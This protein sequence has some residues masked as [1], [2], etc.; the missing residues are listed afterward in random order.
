MRSDEVGVFNRETRLLIVRFH[1][2]TT[3][4]ETGMIKV[5]C[6]ACKLISFVP[7][8]HALI[9]LLLWT[10]AISDV[11]ANCSRPIQVPVAISGYIV[12]YRDHQFSGMIPDFLSLIEQKSNCR[13]T[14]IHVPKNRQEIM[15]ERGEADLLIATVKTD[16]RQKIG[17][18]I[19]FIKLR[20]TLISVESGQAPIHRFR[21]LLQRKELKLVVVRAYD[22]GPE[23]RSIVEAMHLQKRLIVETDSVSVARLMRGNPHYVTIMTPTLFYGM[24]QTEQRLEGMAGKVRYET[25][26]ELDW[27][28]S[29]IYV[30]KTSLKSSEQNFLKS[31]IERLAT[32]DAIWKA[33]LQ[34]YPADVVKVGM[35]RRD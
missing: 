33:Y 5:K 28:E 11:F 8:K 6:S 3:V 10:S 25:V 15:F 34:H 7:Y 29:G 13:F 23:Y 4:F 12:M 31:Q 26:T 17:D 20:P 2:L 30:S 18:F 35:R 1:Q 19:P 16:R 27:I 14:Y 9:L 24:V 22:Y 32:T 21:D